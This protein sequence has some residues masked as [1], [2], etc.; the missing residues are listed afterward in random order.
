MNEFYEAF[1][2]SLTT[3]E[4]KYRKSIEPSFN[5]PNYFVIG[6]PRSGTTVLT[7]LV[8]NSFNIG[9]PNN[10]IAKFW[11]APLVGFKLF[12]DIFSFHFKSDYSSNYGVGSNSFSPHEFSFFWQK[13]IG[14]DSSKVSSYNPE[15]AKANII[16]NE[17]NILFHQVNSI[18]K[19]PIVYK[20]LELLGYH[21]IEFQRHVENSFFIYIKRAPIEVA[22]S[23][24]EG[25][26]VKAGGINNWY[27]SYPEE[28]NKLK[29]NSFAEEI[30]YQV[31][32]LNKMYEK[33]ISKLDRNCFIEIEY[34][35]LINSPMNTLEK[36]EIFLGQK[37]INNDLLKEIRPSSFH[38]KLLTSQ[39]IALIKN[40]FK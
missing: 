4:E 26:K 28:R 5:I 29:F 18:T 24:A 9:C 31:S 34:E 8:F 25:R 37:A 22:L 17:L 16:W 3:L 38:S 30:K 33:K 35:E 36:L 2:S 10:F 1:N 13:L 20:P 15:K 11:E 39:E 6:L 21:L 32:E 7:Q 12:I 23:L 19:I 14:M 40:Q 27:S